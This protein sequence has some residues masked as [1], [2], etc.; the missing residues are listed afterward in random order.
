MCSIVLGLF[1]GVGMHMVLRKKIGGVHMS[2]N[3]TLPTHVPVSANLMSRAL[4]LFCLYPQADYT[5]DSPA[6]SPL[7]GSP[8]IPMSTLFKCHT[9]PKACTWCTKQLAV[10]FEL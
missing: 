7:G 8:F 5:P 4:L 10:W 1:I 3:L 2:S 9:A 6:H